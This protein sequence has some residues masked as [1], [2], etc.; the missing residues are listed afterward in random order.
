MKEPHSNLFLPFVGFAV[1]CGITA[2]ATFLSGGPVAVTAS[3]AGPTADPAAA[4]VESSLVLPGT[5]LAQQSKAEPDTSNAPPVRPTSNA[6]SAGAR[7]QNETV[8]VSERRRPDHEQSRRVVAK[9]PPSSDSSDPTAGTATQITEDFPLAPAFEA[10]EERPQRPGRLTLTRLNNRAAPSAISATVPAGANAGVS[11]SGAALTPPGPGPVPDT[12]PETGRVEPLPAENAAPANPTS[13][14]VAEPASDSSPEEGA[15]TEPA[16]DEP[17]NPLLRVYAWSPTSEP[18]IRNALRLGGNETGL[19]VLNHARAAWAGLEPADQCILLAPLAQSQVP[20]IQGVALDRLVVEGPDLSELKRWWTDTLWTL[21]TNG[22]S[23]RRVGMDWESGFSY[24]A[25]LRH[26]GPSDA[27]AVFGPVWDRPEARAMLPQLLQDAAPGDI[28]HQHRRDLVIA[29]NQ[30]AADR[31]NV[32]LREAFAEPLAAAFPEAA[33]SNWQNAWYEDELLDP[34]GW[35]FAHGGIGPESSPAIYG[36]DAAYNRR[37]LLAVHNPEANTTVPWL[38]FPSHADDRDAWVETV[39]T[40]YEMGVR[41]F[42]YWNPPVR[43]KHP[44]DDAF[45]SKVFLRLD[46]RLRESDIATSYD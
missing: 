32:A 4:Q 11:S 33:I 35:P 7:V 25:L 30:F 10:S 20:P 18:G 36:P 38:D 1:I 46:P 27:A 24:W 26:S 37:V 29:W 9:A 23:P 17:V 45:A 14:T 12:R 5:A 8:Q 21:Q 22:F 42:L 28:H 19:T 39:E 3:T 15:H 31:L 40:A 43:T 41:E 6:Y 16:V 2:A 13:Q 44:D 34:N